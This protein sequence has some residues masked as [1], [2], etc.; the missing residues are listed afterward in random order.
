MSSRHQRVLIGALLAVALVGAYFGRIGGYALQDPDE[1]RYAEIS[2][3]MAVSGD[4][5]TPTLHHVKYFDKPPLLYWLVAASFQMVGVSEGAARAVPAGAGVLTVLITFALGRSMF[6]ARPAVLG[7]LVLATTPLFFFF[8]QGLTID[9]LLTAT[10]TAT[11]STLWAFQTSSHPQRWALV[12]AATTA[13]GVLAKGL[14]AVV[15]PGLTMLGFLLYRGELRALGSLLGLRPI[16][17]F[18]GLAVPW[19][20]AMSW[21]SPEFAHYFF[22]TQ[23]VERFVTAA[24][25]HPEGPLFYV[26]VLAAGALPWTVVVAAVVWIRGGVPWRSRDDATVFLVL[27]TLVVLVFFSAARSKLPGYI[28]PAFPPLALL[29]GRLL[30]SDDDR[31]SVHRVASRVVHGFALLGGSLALLAAVT[32]PF[33]RVVSDRLGRDPDDVALVLWTS[34]T[35]GLGLA[36]IA[37]ILGRSWTHIGRSPARSIAAIAGCIGALLLL[38]V[39]AR[40]VVKNSREIGT[41]VRALYEPGDVLVSYKRLLHGLPFYSDL[42]PI[43]AVSYGELDFGSRH[44]SGSKEF[45]WADPSRVVEAWGSGRRVFVV[46]TRKYERELLDVLQPPPHVLARD[47]DRVVLVNFAAPRDGTEPPTDDAARRAGATTDG[48]CG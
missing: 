42:R 32:L 12:V 35:A 41:A 25:G 27:W 1:G 43:H 3:E 14:V 46:T 36:A 4:W 30:S 23:H 6:G 2:R 20:V 26:P 9:M 24:V 8:S 38:A 37:L 48:S 47:A 11:M 21:S 29:A 40:D 5:L 33:M 28:L 10:M 19:F 18:V 31:C 17:L 22:V 34:L 13:I 15:L 39:P 45:F 44:T 16:L 7:A